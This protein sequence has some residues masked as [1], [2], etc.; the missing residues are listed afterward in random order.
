MSEFAATDLR[1]RRVLPLLRRA[2]RRRRRTAC[3]TTS[4]TCVVASSRVRRAVVQDD[5]RSGVPGRQL[6]RHR[7]PAA[8]RRHP[9]RSASTTRTPM[10]S[11]SSKSD[12][13]WAPRLGFSWDVMGDSTFKVFGN[14]G[15]YFIPVA[16]T[17]PRSVPRAPKPRRPSSSSTRAAIRSPVPRC[18]ATQLG[19]TWAQRLA[20]TAPN[21]AHRRRREPEPDVPGRIHPGHAEAAQREL[22]DRSARHQ[23]RDQGRLRRHLRPQPLVDWATDNGYTNF[24]PASTA[25]SATS[26]TRAVTPSSRST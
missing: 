22:D 5:Q 6:E 13:L 1:R 26:S 2:G 25:A 3:R 15:R 7:Q 24:D 19:P 18:S 20:S 10:A 9:R 12:D 8:V 17:T 11:R 23:A 14:A 21:P 4:R 16:S